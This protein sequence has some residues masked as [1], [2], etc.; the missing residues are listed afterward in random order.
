MKV[1]FILENQSLIRSRKGSY[2]EATYATSF[3]VKK[4]PPDEQAWTVLNMAR[5]A[6]CTANEFLRKPCAEISYNRTG[7]VWRMTFCNYKP[8]PETMQILLKPAKDVC[9]NDIL[10]ATVC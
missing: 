3:F 7:G 4:Y 8:L 10:I 5:D 2:Y 9:G 1:D 6:I